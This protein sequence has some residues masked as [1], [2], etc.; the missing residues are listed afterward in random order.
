M[1]GCLALMAAAPAPAVLAKPHP[2]PA[3]A[4]ATSAH[5]KVDKP[6]SHL[7]FHATANG[8]GFDGEFRS[9]D[10]DIVFDPKALTTS[11][12]TVTVIMASA[13]THDATRDQMLPTGDWFDVGKFATATFET[14][15]IT[16]VGPGKYQAAGFLTMHGVKRPA[17]LPFSLAITGDVAHMDGALTLDRT[18][19]GVG[20]GQAGGTETVAAQVNVAVKLTATRVH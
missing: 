14:T 4:A 11:H 18:A 15:A 9:W 6:A 20:K 7:S 1:A 17:T 19:F 5:W 8:V 12:A 3:A 16:S 13:V 10:A 2:K